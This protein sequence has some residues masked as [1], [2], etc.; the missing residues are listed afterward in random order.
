MKI[1]KI[2]AGALTLALSLSITACGSKKD[3]S[4]DESGSNAKKA[5]VSATM[6]TDQGGINDK[7]FNQS[8][9]EGL[10]AYEKDGKVKFDYIESHKDSDYQPNLESALDS[11]S[12]IIFTVGYALFDATS[13]AAKEN[14]DQNYAI[15]DNANPD[16]V[17]N[18]LGITF[19]DHENSF[20][21]GYIAGMTTKSN[22][23]G[24]VGGMESAVIDRFEY[25]YRAGV[26]E[27]AREKGQDIEVQVQ[28]ANSYADQAKGKNIANQM[29]QKGA[30][31]IFHAAGGTGIGV[32]EAAKENNKYVIGVDRD[33]KD[34]APDN[35]L[36]STIKGVGKA[37]QLTIDDYKDGKFK[38]GETKSYSLKDGDALG[39][40]YGD[41]DLVDQKVKDKV[42]DLRNQIVDGKIKVPQNEKE[43][44]SMGYDK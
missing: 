29:Y 38:G 43:F 12:D 18:L 39:I 2:M 24:F 26:K 34:E 42:E 25:G 31:V 30:D 3:A 8:S 7:S 9:Y 22:N 37:V 44:K 36:V 13:K 20:L 14:P 4:N 11:E 40:A 10:K 23:V 33:Q 21:V 27:A 35:I 15:I 1:K 5:E 16:K 19:A 41:N 32:F 6:V 17:K 28:Y